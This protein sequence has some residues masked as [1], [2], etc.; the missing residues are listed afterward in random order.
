MIFYPLAQSAELKI[1]TAV[2]S[3]A[4]QDIYSIL[5]V[6]LEAQTRAKQPKLGS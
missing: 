5:Y 4:N 6:A 3:L 1:N 2:T